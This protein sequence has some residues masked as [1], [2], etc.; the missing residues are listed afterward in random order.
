MA[1]RPTDGEEEFRE[2]EASLVRITLGP[3]VWAVHLLL[4]YAATA[5]FC[6][7]LEAPQ[8]AIEALRWGIAGATLLAL[9][10]IGWLGLRSWRQ[11]RH[12]NEDIWDDPEGSSEDRH[13]FLG[14]AALLLAV[15][16][17]IGVVYTALPAF[18]SAS[19]R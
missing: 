4:S 16:S 6:A 2:E 9:G 8:E 19:C 7:K 13:Q 17:F 14:H 11:W 5:V 1:Q 3:L 15:I 10:V 12:G 18:L